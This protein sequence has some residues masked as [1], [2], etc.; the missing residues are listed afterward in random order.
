MKRHKR[1]W[2]LL[3][4]PGIVSLMG[5][6]VLADKKSDSGTAGA[7]LSDEARCKASLQRFS[8]HL[9]QRSQPYCRDLYQQIQ[10]FLKA[11]EAPVSPSQLDKCENFLS[12]IECIGVHAESG[13]LAPMPA[14]SGAQG[15]LQGTKVT[16]PALETDPRRPLIR[17]EMAADPEPAREGGEEEEEGGPAGFRA[18]SPVAGAKKPHA[19]EETKEF[20]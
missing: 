12:I 20:E 1:G 19:S 10:D 18:R 13:D 8:L 3:L 2:V 5:T 7:A 17:Y 6:G 11:W 9:E 14:P 16:K 15:G 4:A